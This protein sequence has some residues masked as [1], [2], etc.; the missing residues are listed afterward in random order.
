MK[1][2]AIVPA[3]NE[4]RFIALTLR[5][6]VE[7]TLPPDR[8]YVVDDGSTDR[9]P[10][11]VREFADETGTVHLVRLPRRAE[12]RMGGGVV[13]AFNA[14]YEQCRHLEFTYVSK[15]DADHVF[16]PDYFERVLGHLDAHPDWAAAGGVPHEEVGGRVRGWKMQKSHVPG[17]LK[18]VRKD[19]F[20]RMGG[21][22]PTL[23]WDIV[24]IVKMHSLGYRTGWLD[25]PVTHLRR[26]A[27]AEGTLKGKAQW[28]EGAWI[29]GSHPLYVLARGALQIAHPPYV[30]SG[31]AFW[32]GYLAAA[33]KQQPRVP[34]PELVRALRREQVQRLL[35]FNRT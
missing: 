8:I 20:D 26:H 34:D 27:S 32:W 24:D 5:S 15:L 16:P 33:W 4:E 22:L 23:G 3:R 29:L 30:L 14:G 13:H 28:G 1:H 10:D 25:I 17:S 21:F 7:Q 19:V 6:L 12:R 11:I 18:T 9:T 35:G 31:F 2:I